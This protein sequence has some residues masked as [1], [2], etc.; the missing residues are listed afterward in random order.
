MKQYIK[1]VS[2]L[3]H[4]RNSKSNRKLEES[5]HGDECV[6]DLKFIE[7]GSEEDD[8]TSF[9]EDTSVQHPNVIFNESQLDSSSCLD[10][11]ED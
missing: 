2:T 6:V 1:S 10:S 9:G 8:G 7:E 3:I 5:D 4:K 11:S